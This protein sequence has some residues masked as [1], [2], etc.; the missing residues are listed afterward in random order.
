VDNVLN[1]PKQ[2]V[3][4][5]IKKELIQTPIKVFLTDENS[6][7]VHKRKNVA[8]IGDSCSV[9]SSSSKS[10]LMPTF[11]YWLYEYRKI[12]G[13]FFAKL[14]LNFFPLDTQD[15]SIIITTFKSNKHVKLIQNTTKPSL[16]NS[17]TII[18]QNIW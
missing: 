4:F 14:E 3:H 11:S 9:D 15:L 12:R 18:D 13:Y 6:N 17:K 7:R 16:I 8:V 10:S 5:K 2:H 1:E